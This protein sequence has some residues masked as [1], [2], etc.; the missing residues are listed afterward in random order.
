MT[1]AKLIN[2]EHLSAFAVVIG[3]LIVTTLSAAELADRTPLSFLSLAFLLFVYF[4]CCFFEWC[5]GDNARANHTGAI[6]PWSAFVGVGITTIRSV[7]AAYQSPF[8]LCSCDS[9]GSGPDE[10]QQA[11]SVRPARVFL[12]GA[13]GNR[14]LPRSASGLVRPFTSTCLRK[15]MRC[16]AQDFRSQTEASSFAASKIGVDVHRWPAQGPPSGRLFNPTD[17]PGVLQLVPRNTPRIRVKS[18][19]ITTSRRPHRRGS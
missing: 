1:L 15:R 16:S 19:V 9:R 6:A 11:G 13:L 18:A 3:E 5:D 7:H 8:A 14:Y 4:A 12:G 10:I 17:P 2:D